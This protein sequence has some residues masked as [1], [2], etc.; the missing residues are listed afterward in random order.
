MS[1]WNGKTG[2][3]FSSV[4]NIIWNPWAS[5]KKKKKKTWSKLEDQNSDQPESEEL[6]ELNS[7]Q[8]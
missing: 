4:P 5:E 3:L 8:Q 6:D 7:I 1:I 2:D